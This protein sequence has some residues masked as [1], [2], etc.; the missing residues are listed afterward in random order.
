M[1]KNIETALLTDIRRNVT[2]LATCVVITRKD[3]KPYYLTSHD[4]D[5]TFNDQVYRHDIPFVISATDSG[6]QLSIDNSVMTL[7]ADGVTFVRQQFEDGLFDFADCEIFQVNY[8]TPANGK[9]TL[10][11]GWFGQFNHNRKDVLEITVTGLLKTLDFEVGRTYQPSCDA[12]LGDSRCKVA[13]NQEQL[14]STWNPYRAGDWVYNYDTSLMTAITLTNGSFDVD[15]LVPE[16]QTIP[17]W[18][19]TSG[20]GSFVNVSA[21]SPFYVEDIG[22]LSPAHGAAALYGSR[23]ATDDSNGF[24]SRVYQDVDLIASGLTAGAIDDGQI[25]LGLFGLFA[26][27]AYTLDPM[28]FRIELTNSDGEFVSAFDSRPFFLAETENWHE[29]ALVIP[30]YPG[31]RTARI[32]IGFIKEDGAVANCAADNI[33][34][35]WWN[36]T[37]SNPYD[38]VVHRLTRIVSVDDTTVYR[39]SNHSFEAN[40]NVAAAD[41]PTIDG[42]TTGA[43]NWWQIDN[44]IG[45]PPDDLAV[46]VDSYF[47][48]GGDDSS[49]VQKT[50]TITQTVAIADILNITAE[51]QLLAKYVGVFKADVG[52]WGTPT[53][54]T[55]T[56][57]AKLEF[58]DA[59]N[60]VLSTYLAIDNQNYAG[61]VGLWQTNSVS[62]SV[63]ALAT[64]VRVTL[65][66]HSP[67]GASAAKVGFDNIRMHL[68]DAERPA[69]TDPLS[70]P[71]V[72]ASTEMSTI[73]GSY[74][75][76]GALIWKTMAASLAYDQVASV[77]DRKTFSGVTISGAAGSYETG[78]IWWISGRNAG[79]KNVVRIWTP[80]TKTLKMYFRQPYAIAPGDRFIYVRSC[81]RRFTEDCQLIFQNQ[82]NFRGFPHLPGKVRDATTAE[83]EAG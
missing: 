39:F 15:T 72:L 45:T 81:Q 52:F 20:S 63:P 79:L 6:S 10:R 42:W 80:D 7:H 38:D 46:E 59:S 44:Q 9:M 24:E 73:V 37:V 74:T 51:R 62:F 55:S 65:Q 70:S 60:A 53:P 75:V 36:H 58:L 34:L 14:R 40:T 2:T 56:A 67:S 66:A 82:I 22:N 77:V 61:L 48:G 1:S 16:D 19:R 25:T 71:A 4:E 29:K 31:A 54:G 76:D 13:I 41:N 35:Y 68:F 69:K 21:D 83:N 57:T 3:G 17:G 8:E 12:D 30:V 50:Y 5:I 32:I 33:R 18:T 27:T 11:K 78:I 28:R 43:G 23:D 64:Q 47:L 49:G 26:T